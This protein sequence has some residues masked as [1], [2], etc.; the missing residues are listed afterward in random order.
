M[1]RTIFGPIQSRRFGLS[2]GIDLS[3]ERKSCNYD[4][5]YCELKPA[6]VTDHIVH[7]PKVEEIMTEVERAM[8][9]FSD[10]DVVT[11]T[12][13]GE[14]TLYEDLDT[15]V[16]TL[17]RIKGEKKLLILSNASRIMEPEIQKTLSK[18]DIVK[19][20]LDCASQRCFKRIDRPMRGVEIEK[21]IEGMKAFRKMYE[22]ELIVETL[23]VQGIN[24]KEEEMEAL[25]AVLKQICPDRI[26]LG[27]IDRP[28]A[29]DVK[30][31]STER[32]R[33][34]AS[35]LGALPISIIHKEEPKERIDFSEEEILSTI[36]RRPQS[37]SDV[38]YLFSEAAKERL[39]KLI[40]EGKVKEK[41]IAGV[42]FFTSA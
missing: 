42:R 1:Y 20:S 36:K 6:K 26:D 18:I 24:D 8:E 33:E 25:A 30:P 9:E 32:L 19:L 10:L 29:Y 4:C 37:V 16:D 31:V 2:L 21:I 40:E 38:A 12:A 17:N 34:L 22:G 7:P 35:Y 3:P 41:E 23:V 5:L 14:P 13:N 27:T 28:P 39:Q 11:I 15:L